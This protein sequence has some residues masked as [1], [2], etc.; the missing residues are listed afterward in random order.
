M[1]QAEINL[2]SHFIDSRFELTW[3]E[4]S[5]GSVTWHFLHEY[6]PSLHLGDL[7]SQVK[8]LEGEQSAVLAFYAGVQNAH[9]GQAEKRKGGY[10]Q[11][12]F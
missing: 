12:R 2:S 4:I 6:N 1:K 7:W 9:V 10:K 5:L 11:Y 8:S 3:I